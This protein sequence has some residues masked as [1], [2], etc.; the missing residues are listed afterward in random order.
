MRRPVRSLLALCL[1]L[2][3]LTLAGMPVAGAEDPPT[4]D[5]RIPT[6]AT[7]MQAVG[8]RA[9]DETLQPVRDSLERIADL[10]QQISTLRET[11]RQADSR[12]NK[13]R[14]SAPAV[15]PLPLPNAGIPA[16]EKALD[17]AQ[18][19]L[20][21][22]QSRLSQLETELTKL[23]MQPTQ[24]RDDIARLEGEL[25]N[26]A[27]SF[28]AQA[29]DQALSPSLLTQAARY[30]LLDTEISLRQTKLQTHPMRLAL[31]AAERDQLR[32]LQRT[33]QAR[34]D[35]LIQRLGRSRLLSADQATAETLR[36]IEQ[37]DSRHPMIRNLAAENAALADELTALARTLD[38][39]SRDNENTL[40]QLEDV[41]T[42]YRSAQTQIE[43]AGVG[44]TLSRVLHE[45]RKRLPD[46]Q[47]YRQQAR[48]RSEQIAQTRLRQFQIDEKR[49]Q[50]ADTAQ[51][52]RARLQDED[53]QLQLDTRQTDRL[54]AEAELLLD[55]QKDL[56]EQLSRSYLTLID[57]L[58]QLDLSQKR[59]TQI[60]AD[61]TRLLDEN[62][63]WIASDLPI[64]SAWFVEL[65]NELTALTDPARWQRVRHATLIEAQSRPLIVALALLTLLATVWSRP[66]LR[67]YLQWTG[68]E[69]G[70]PAHDRFSLTVG[71][72]LAS[73]VLALPLPILAGLLGWMLQQQGS[74]DRFVWG[75]SDGLIHAA[76]I[77]W[78]I[79][80]FRRLASRGGVLEAHFR[81][82]PQTRELLYRNLRWLVILT[83]LATVLMRLAAADPRG[84]SMPVLGRAV[85]IVFSV[86]LVVFIARIFHPARGVL[87]AWLQS[88]H[89]GWAW[90]G[91]NLSYV[92][93]LASASVLAVMP[94]FG[95]TY[96]AVHLQSRAFFTGWL[97]A[98]SALVISLLIRGLSV[99]LRHIEVARAGQEL[100]DHLRPAPEEPPAHATGGEGATLPSREP[101]MDLETMNEQV[102][103]LLKLALSVM[104][105]GGL[106]VIWSDIFGALKVLD[107]ITLW[108]IT[109]PSGGDAPP[110]VQAITLGSIGLAL[111]ALAL[112]VSAARNIPG[113]LEVLVLQRQSVDAGTR[114][115][116]TLLSRYAIFL[117]GLVVVVNQL[118][119]DWS[120]AQWLV[121]ALSVGLGF[122][123]QEIVANFVAGIIILFERPIRIGDTVTVGG[124]S[125]TVSRI[126]IR[127]TTILDWDRKELIVPNKSFV[128]DSIINWT[129]SDLV[130]RTI[131]PVGIAYGSDTQKALSVMETVI[132]DN[133]LILKEPVPAVLF[134]GFGDSS[135]NF[136]LRV[137]VKTLADS[138]LVRHQLHMELERRLREAGI[139]IPFPQRDVHLRSVS[140]EAL[141][142][143]RTPADERH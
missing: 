123:L 82:Q 18:R 127:A 24:L 137:F 142:G 48:T 62:L 96:T 86:A 69:V 5:Q 15:E 12:I 36:A 10:K 125:G 91:R 59:L 108:S 46:L 90:R 106:Y 64:R 139:E 60:G 16:M 41:E 79:E 71:A 117:V 115:A 100:M 128:T 11:A 107:R 81:W 97:L 70:N 92:L 3:M 109:A 94:I 114:Y 66:K 135:L 67:R 37:A 1:A 102:R 77:S 29:N 2:L 113:L 52:A 98:A 88:H 84:L 51:A 56:L 116:A 118:G 49:R 38:E 99:S 110:T 74:N 65:F 130:T 129:L 17:S 6:M 20:S 4:F 43:I 44:Q 131:I 50:L 63:L 111:V 27:A 9:E 136:E 80:S 120:K 21:E 39:V 34:V 95:Y 28:P 61:Y 19:R 13:L 126:R 143:F 104:V 45:Q 22:T 57:R 93:L 85:Y 105:L 87:G 132:H 78:V 122:G 119:I 26:L 25:D 32:G 133:A 112:T 47:A 33:L 40:R 76:W 30:R 73:F 124:V 103:A 8:Q 138:I 140:P 35:V 72:A 89:E 101:M 31:L 58:S 141:H 55:S 75:L 14:R 68:T 53:P 42:L 54:L 134:L 83:A 121:A 23:T 7:I